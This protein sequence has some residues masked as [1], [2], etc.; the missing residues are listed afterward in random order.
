MKKH[1]LLLSPVLHRDAQRGGLNGGVVEESGGDVGESQG[2][3]ALL[4]WLGRGALHML[5][6]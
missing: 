5:Q 3:N 4:P 6:V 1:Q 2:R